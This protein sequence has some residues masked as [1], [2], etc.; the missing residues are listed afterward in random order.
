[1]KM[2]F[3]FFFILS[4]S[5][6]SLAQSDVIN[7]AIAFSHDGQYAKADSLYQSGISQP[8]IDQN[9][10]QLNRAFNYSWW[11]QYDLADQLFRSLLDIPE[12]KVETLV[13][14]A[15]NDLWAGRSANS[16]QYFRDALVLERG[17]LSAL[18]GLI[19]YYIDAKNPAGARSTLDDLLAFHPANAEIYYLQGLIASLELRPVQAKKAFKLALKTDPLYRAA[20][21]KLHAYTQT[22]NRFSLGIWHGTSVHP[23]RTTHDLRRIDLLFQQNKKLLF[24]AGYDNSLAMQN[25]FLNLNREQAPFV[26]IGSKY[27][28]SRKA[29]LKA[30]IGRRWFQTKADEMMYQVEGDY[31]LNGQLRLAGRVILNSSPETNLWTIGFGGEFALTQN[32]RLNLNYFNTQTIRPNHSTQH[33]IVFEP[34]FYANNIEFIAGIFYDQIE[35]EQIQKGNIAGYYTMISFP[36]V[37]RLDGRIFV[38]RDIGVFDQPTTL[39]SF[40]LNIKF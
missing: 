8:S 35:I 25:G 36:I 1:M 11:G 4:I 33:R 10:L 15:Y 18:L 30:E 20:R 3:V 5:L 29:S 19:H 38:Q 14:L 17:H 2:K 24:I 7:D 39:L 32:L 28:L 40:G 37:N 27:R 12:L 34:K 16:V 13:G 22:P 23:E 9:N 6:S 31:V 21:D 26:F